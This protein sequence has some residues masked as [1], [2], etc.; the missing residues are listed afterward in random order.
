MRSFEQYIDESYSFRLGGSQN[1]GYEQNEV[2]IKTF[3]ELE[4]DDTF[5]FWNS[6]RGEYANEYLFEK[7]ERNYTNL[8]YSAK[9]VYKNVLEEDFPFKLI[10][11][12]A[13]DS[14]ISFPRST[15]AKWCIATSFEE[16]VKTVKEKFGIN[17][18]GFYSYDGELTK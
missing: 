4:E 3:N 13:L 12:D 2:K 15:N 18:K 8:K 5:Y 6:S 16:L 14:T 7:L 9:I 10:S 1:K 17:I 11:K